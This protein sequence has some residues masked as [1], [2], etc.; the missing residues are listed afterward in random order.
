MCNKKLFKKGTARILAFMLAVSMAFPGTVFAAEDQETVQ[1]QAEETG[2]SDVTDELFGADSEEAD[3]SEKEAGSTDEEADST[4]EEADSTYE[5]ADNTDE[6][7]DST[8]EE[9]A[10]D[11]ALNAEDNAVEGEITDGG[12]DESSLSEDTADAEEG[13]NSEETVPSE[14][15]AGSGEEGSDPVEED[16]DAAPSEEDSEAALSEGEEQ[17]VLEDKEDEGSEETD[18]SALTQ[19]QDGEDAQSSENEPVVADEEKEE[20]AAEAPLNAEE[21]NVNLIDSIEIDSGDAYSVSL[22]LTGRNTYQ[23][24]VNVKYMT[25]DKPQNQ[26]YSF[27]SSDEKVLKVSATGLVTAVGTGSAS[28]KVYI[29]TDTTQ[30]YGYEDSLYIT[31]YEKLYHVTYDLNG[32]KA[33]DSYYE[34]RLKKGDDSYD[35]ESVY[36]PSS[37]YLKKEGYILTGWTEVKNGN[38]VLEGSYVPEKN[39]TLYAKWIK[40][41]TV[42]F[43]VN[44]GK[45]VNDYYGQDRVV[46][47]GEFLYLNT[48]TYVATKAGYILTGW[49]ETKNGSTVYTDNYIPKK[50]ITLYAKWKKAYTIKYNANGG[51][52]SEYYGKDAIVEAGKTL[53][54]STGDYVATKAGYV[55]T[56]WK[57]KGGKT[58][59]SGEY[60][61]T[62]SVTLYANW[63]KTFNVTLNAGKGSFA[64]TKKAKQIIKI[65]TGTT[66]GEFI[67]YS[68]YHPTLKG[69]TFVGWYK[70]AKLTRPVKKSDVINKNTT[71]YARY[72]KKTIKITVT[73]L[74][75]ASYYNRATGKYVQS[76]ESK[77]TSYSFYINKGDTIGSLDADKNG[78]D[79]QFFF[80]KACKEKPFYYSFEPTGNTTIYAKWRG[81]VTVNWDGNGGENGSG[82]AS[83]S[84]YS[85]K[86][87][88]CENLPSRMYRK[89]YY[90]IGWYDVANPKKIL[91]VSH[92]FSKDTNV[93][94]K[95]G[96]G[97]KITFNAGGGKFYEGDRTVFYV[98]AKS[99]LSSQIPYAPE[100]EKTGYILK[101]WKNS[102]T[103][104]VVTDIYSQKPSKNTTFTAVWMKKNNPSNVQVTL[105]AGDGSIYDPDT[106]RYVTK[107][108]VNI[109]K[110]TT[111]SDSFKYLNSSSHDDP[112]KKLYNYGW[113]LSKNGKELK[114]S[115]KFTKKVTLYPLWKAGSMVRVALVTN[116]GSLYGY[117]QNDPEIESAQKGTVIS[118]PTAKDME[119]EGYTFVGWYKDYKLKNKVSSPSK[120]K[121]TKNCYLYAKWKK[122]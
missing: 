62:K 52:F 108:V 122:K 22:G 113:S 81:E 73:N 20:T 63:V 120:Y 41:Y 45:F 55:L 37:Y 79:A 65:A 50:N 102:V 101:G 66:A 58:V 90:F 109:P 8:D 11:P 2:E 48:G 25:T 13:V 19:E 112:T 10:Q 111:Y 88:M 7:A 28:V 53:Y 92:V 33:A 18:S 36:L 32:G 23:V 34:G 93:K 110:N 117:P 105:V 17:A 64:A 43:N 84:V 5:E 85:K 56:G 121:L 106:D 38:T 39:I 118:L 67:R 115:Y 98:K 104:K 107:R 97:I 3:D 74:K 57:L 103:K 76:S 119:R 59:Y 26:P 51:K 16:L 1:V 44:G 49:T 89:D 30:E 78:E 100:V 86:T 14:E 42:K 46:K 72:N 15:A 35:G 40:T 91:P 99:A 9:E 71:F 77:A 114:G 12:E 75:G 116:G 96:K 95:W 47:A 87:L 69:Q 6:E 60:K 61:P 82:Y 24:A 27:K 80:D 54:L 4:D 68:E 70:D 21:D 83:G 31:V 94:A 29:G